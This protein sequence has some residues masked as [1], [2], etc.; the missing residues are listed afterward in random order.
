MSNLIETKSLLAK[1]MATENIHIEQRNVPTASF[2]L[3]SR[4]LTVPI[5]NNN[6]NADTYDLFM[7][8]EVGHALYTDYVKWEK[9][10][11]DGENMSVLNVVEDFRIE[12][13]VKY[14]YPGLK[15]A[16][17]RAYR[18]LFEKNFFRTAGDDLNDYNLIDRINLHSKVG[19]TLN[20]QFNEIER[21]LLSDLE[22]IQTI[23]DSI[24]VQRKIVE[25]MKIQEEEN[26]IFDKFDKFDE[27]DEDHEDSYDDGHDSEGSESEEK[28]SKSTDEPES[29]ENQDD[30]NDSKSN[31]KGAD[32]SELNKKEELSSK[33]G[34]GTPEHDIR[35]H[36]DDA[37]KENEHRLFNSNGV[38]KIY[39]NAPSAN[40]E[41][42]IVDFKRLYAIYDTQVS[43]NRNSWRPMIGD[44]DTEGY[45]QLRN[46]I[47]KTVSYLVKEFELRKNAEQ[48]KKAS[49]AKTGDLNLDKIFSY[50]FNEDI[51]KKL[52]VTNQGK[53]H[54]LVMFIDWSGS[55]S[56][57][58][59]NTVKQLF[60]IVL[61]CK[62]VNIPYE[63]YAFSDY[64]GIDSE[65]YNSQFLQQKINKDDIY[66][67]PA[68]KLL[69][70]LS[71]RMN[72]SQFTKAASAL[73]HIAKNQNEIPVFCLGGT[74][75]NDTILA[76]LDIVPEF[77]KKNNLQIV[78]TIFL[79]DGESNNHLETFDEGGKFRAVHRSVLVPKKGY[80]IRDIVVRDNVTRH[81]VVI[82]GS[83][84]QDF[85]NGYLKL[86][87]HRTNSNIIGFYILNT[88]E[89]VRGINTY[90]PN[91]M[92]ET[93]MQLRESFINNN[94]LIATNQ[95]Y[96]EYYLMKSEKTN[97]EEDTFT[98]RG[99]SVKSIANAFTKFASKR[100]NNRTVLNRFIGLIS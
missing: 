58:L 18:D 79:T 32:E 89:I 60:N 80:M 6:I 44:Y 76:A 92:Y 10:C 21:G 85:T 62:K 43:S 78:N 20:I 17:I 22:N 41:N 72:A 42:I 66:I 55:M 57:H 77:K 24:D 71:S 31:S 99:Q 12:K 48:M 70:I 67:T 94:F 45:I 46:S 16:F 82:Q 56:E 30:K 97:K 64:S 26:D 7:G 91:S 19:A 37:F 74:P 81:E 90:F 51:F 36:T 73:V 100:S 59:F 69:N 53:S 33:K 39:L 98:V 96:D 15:N 13:K 11:K 93:I 2:D 87:K 8:H 68:L 3:K 5:L 95:G 88:K 29:K 54:G 1:L 14:K 23:E 63:V 38:E 34:A 50:Q 75:L 49:V 65:K 61:F 40:L 47:N 4:I 35:S 83:D 84:A 9:A 25:Y 52:T 27:E 28:G 86:L